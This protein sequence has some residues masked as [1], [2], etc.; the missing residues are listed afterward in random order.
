MHFNFNYVGITRAHRHTAAEQLPLKLLEIKSL[1]KTL[2]CR[3]GRALPSLSGKAGIWTGDVQFASLGS[4]RLC[5]QCTALNIQ[6]VCVHMHVVHL[7]ESALT[8][9]LVQCHIVHTIW[10]RWGVLPQDPS[11]LFHFSYFLGPFT[12]LIFA[13]H[14][15]AF[16]SHIFFVYDFLLDRIR[17]MFYLLMSQVTW[18]YFPLVSSISFQ[19]LCCCYNQT[20]LLCLTLV[21][22]EIKLLNMMQTFSLGVF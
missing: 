6:H 16:S 18:H 11:C 10:F 22:R 8:C 1:T 3:F 15:V 20:P 5:T 7:L 14:F 12:L 21:K 17:M 2:C 19:Q 13:L 9:P 4:V